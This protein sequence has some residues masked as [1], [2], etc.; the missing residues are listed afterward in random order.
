MQFLSQLFLADNNVFCVY[1]HYVK[2]ADFVPV[3]LPPDVSSGSGSDILESLCLS[4][5]SY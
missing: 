4:S 2:N 5:V 3:L 1:L